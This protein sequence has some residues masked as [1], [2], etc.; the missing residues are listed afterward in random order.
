MGSEENEDR[1]R[2][3]L[4]ENPDG[5]SFNRLKEATD[6]STQ[7]FINATKNLEAKDEL[8]SWKDGYKTIFTL[9]FC[10]YCHYEFE[11]SAAKIFNP[12]NSWQNLKSK[13]QR[14]TSFIHFLHQISSNFLSLLIMYVFEDHQSVYR[15]CL[16]RLEEE[17]DEQKKIIRKSFSNKER[18]RMFEEILNIQSY[19]ETRSKIIRD[20]A[21]KRKLRRTIDEI[22]RDLEDYLFYP[23]SNY[24]TPSIKL[25]RT[26]L[27]KNPKARKKYQILEKKYTDLR[28]QMIETCNEL[29]QIS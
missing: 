25:K 9:T 10:D 19:E 1:I 8:S 4:H 6:M 24:K 11:R 27:I 5:L 14:S 17:L 18:Q 29:K 2:K 7:S 13:T 23:S 16:K 28:R 15:V 26:N 12:K 3:A 20:N 21:Q 22:V